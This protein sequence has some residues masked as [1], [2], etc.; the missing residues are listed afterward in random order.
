MIAVVLASWTLYN[1]SETLQSVMTV[2]AAQILQMNQFLHMFLA[3]FRVR[4]WGLQVLYLS[5]YCHY[6]R[7][8]KRQSLVQ[9]PFAMLCCFERKPTQALSSSFES[10]HLI[11]RE[12]LFDHPPLVLLFLTVPL[13]R[14]EYSKHPSSCTYLGTASPWIGDL[15][16]TEQ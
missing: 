11:Q 8:L 6:P 14:D 16:L 2:A 7:S 5:N 15:P 13:P 10:F 9:D 12:A 1:R 4:Y 3:R